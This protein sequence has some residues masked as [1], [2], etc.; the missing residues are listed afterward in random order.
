[1]KG[2]EEK[3]DGKEERRKKDSLS[4]LSLVANEQNHHVNYQQSRLIGSS[5]TSRQA[6][7]ASNPRQPDATVDD[8][9]IT[10]Y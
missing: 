10:D 7:A 8:T 2:G 1:M 9:S 6:L 4:L 5:S 3:G